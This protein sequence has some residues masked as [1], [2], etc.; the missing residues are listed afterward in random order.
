MATAL[1]DT[2]TPNETRQESDT[3][4]TQL[5]DRVNAIKAAKVDAVADTRAL[6]ALAIRP[7]NVPAQVIIQAPNGLKMSIGDVAHQQLGERV[8]IHKKY[9][10]RMLAEAPELLATNLNH[11]FANAPEERLLRMLKPEGLDAKDQAQLVQTGTQVRLR[12]VLG[13]SYRTIDDADLVAAI[14]PTLTERGAQLVD[15]SIDERRMHAKFATVARSV[16]EI[17]LAYAKKYNLTEE[18]VR[19]HTYVDGKD[20]SWVDEVLSSGV[21]IRHSEI[22]FASLG[23]SFFQRILKC[24]NDYVADNAIAIRHAGGKHGSA[25]EDVRFLSDATQLMENAALLGRVQDSIAREL[26]DQVVFERATKILSAK[27][28]IVERPADVPL[29]AFVGNMGEKLGLNQNEVELLKEETQRAVIEEGGERQFA[30]V[31]GITAVARQMTN[32]ERRLDVEHAGFQLLND[33]ASALLKMG[34]AALN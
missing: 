8:G 23:A 21:V 5:T 1:R 32:Y 18:Q 13:K 6:T 27:A 33:D 10:D 15:F 3:R 20:V 7:E 29:F 4:L 26:D 11:W 30:F 25:D 17:R 9:Y 2:A 12:G 31:Q 19:R 22:G 28:T 16:T 24:L 14:L 34:K